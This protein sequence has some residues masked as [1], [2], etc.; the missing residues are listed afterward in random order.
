[1]GYG[2]S[3]P[4]MFKMKH[5]GVPA[6]L[7]AL[8][9]GQK[10]MVSKMKAK[11][12]TAAADKIEKGI[13]AQPEKGA[14]K[15]YGTEPVKK[16]PMSEAEKK[17]IRE[18]QDYR[19]GKGRIK[20]TTSANNRGKGKLAGGTGEIERRLGEGSGEIN[21]KVAGSAGSRVIKD[22]GNTVRVVREK[23][24][25]AFEPRKI[26]KKNAKPKTK[27]VTRRDL[28]L[29]EQTVNRIKKKGVQ[30]VARLGKNKRK[31]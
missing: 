15:K 22:R 9:G 25:Q 26:N 29:K 19:R 17:K 8:T 28:G 2:K 21:T 18:T 6:L 10:D 30:T 13:L 11:G 3:K 12:N 14:A 24:A 27:A 1:M 23:V 20:V 4:G 7:K 16:D 5:Q 31:K